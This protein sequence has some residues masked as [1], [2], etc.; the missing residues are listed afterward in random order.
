[1]STAREKNV[2][3]CNSLSQRGLRLARTRRKPCPAN[4]SRRPDPPPPSPRGA[5][6][7]QNQARRQARAPAQIHCHVAAR[8][9]DVGECGCVGVGPGRAGCAP[10]DGE[11]CSGRASGGTRHSPLAGWRYKATCVRSS[12]GHRPEDAQLSDRRTIWPLSCPRRPLGAGPLPP[13]QR[14][15]RP[16]TPTHPHT[17]TPAH[18]R[19][20]SLFTSPFLGSSGLRRRQARRSRVGVPPNSSPR[21]STLARLVETPMRPG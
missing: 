19:G 13:A 20:V 3:L 2:S 18:Q 4:A 17:H 14:P 8:E 1:M 5:A 12:H 11:R 7:T 21:T 15:P 9:G 6:H 10:D 16:D